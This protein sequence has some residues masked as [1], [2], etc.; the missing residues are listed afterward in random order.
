MDRFKFT[1]GTLIML[2][3]RVPDGDLN[4]IAEKLNSGNA[5]A[6]S[7]TVDLMVAMSTEGLTRQDILNMSPLEFQALEAEA[8]KALGDGAK[9]SIDVEASGTKNADGAEAELS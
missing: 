2:G 3:D 7:F 5:E 9:T 6:L 8:I 1:V 4:K